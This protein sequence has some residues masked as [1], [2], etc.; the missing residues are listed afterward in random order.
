LKKGKKKERQKV[1]LIVE[2]SERKYHL[3]AGEGKPRGGRRSLGE[4][5]FK[6]WNRDSQGVRE[7]R[8]HVSKGYRRGLG[9]MEK[10]ENM[11]TN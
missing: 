3:G 6:K 9:G 4:K 1:G 8:K 11:E 7:L 2:K 10:S 5:S